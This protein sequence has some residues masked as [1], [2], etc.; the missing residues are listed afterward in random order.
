M[1]NHPWNREE[2]IVKKTALPAVW[3]ACLSLAAAADEAPLHAKNSSLPT[4]G[5]PRSYS[6]LFVDDPPRMA[7]M[8]MA[9]EDY[10]G[11]YR[12]VSRAAEDRIPDTSLKV[13]QC[14]ASLLLVPLTHEEGHR[15]VLTARDVGA[16]SRPFPD[17]HLVARVTGV[18][19]AELKNLR[20][21]DLPAYIRL[22]TAGLESDACLLNREETLAAFEQEHVD[23]IWIEY[24]MRRFNQ[25]AYYACGLYEYDVDISEEDEDELDR[26]IV[27]HDVYGA[28]RHLH[29]PDMAFQ[30]YTQFDELT[31]EEQRYARRVGKLGLVNAANPL[32]FGRPNWS[33][34]PGVKCSF[35]L[36]YSMCPFG[37]F[38]E[39][40]GW[41]LV[42][43]DLRLHAYLR[44][45][46]NKNR[47]FP[48]GGL[49]LVDYP[50]GGPFHGSLGLHAWSQPA[51]LSFTESR[52][53]AGGAVDALIRWDV[54]KQ[55]GDRGKSSLSL[56]AGVVIK[57]SGFLPEEASLDGRTSLRLGCTVGF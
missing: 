3:I 41:L 42:G 29:R 51:K 19:D 27:G 4:A 21:T 31:T 2:T 54:L 23:T 9:D 34:K 44:Q 28:I 11:A 55:T 53:A 40:N 26:D 37:D 56:D 13:V 36:G 30:R 6:F 50:L 24:I 12:Y 7:T 52:G 35:G 14:F 33:W 49:R 22:H 39:E 18:R 16:V 32:L 1:L 48:S 38:L 25:I 15:S 43:R 5:E 47:W 17:R 8:K 45:F 20:D 10:L 46:A 57:T